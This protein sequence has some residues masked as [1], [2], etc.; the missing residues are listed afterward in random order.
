VNINYQ[1]KLKGAKLFNSRYKVNSIH[2]FKKLNHHVPNHPDLI[3]GLAPDWSN[4]AH[5]FVGSSIKPPENTSGFRSLLIK[6]LLNFELDFLSG[7]FL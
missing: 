4:Q 2:K 3:I 5:F 1:H 7:L 6:T